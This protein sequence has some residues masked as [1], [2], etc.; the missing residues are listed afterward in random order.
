[1]NDSVKDHMAGWKTLGHSGN[2][3][4]KLLA[5]ISVKRGLESYAAYTLDEAAARIDQLEDVLRG[6]GIV[7]P[8]PAPPDKEERAYLLARAMLEAKH[9]SHDIGTLV[10]S[11]YGDEARDA[12]F[13]RIRQEATGKEGA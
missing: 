12:A 10:W 4:R 5:K 9:E 6:G 8:P 2:G 13:N 3:L 1:M 11:Q 7:V